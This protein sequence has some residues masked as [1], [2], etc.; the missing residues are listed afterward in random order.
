M[1]Y[2]VKTKTLISCSDTA[3]LI[4]AFVFAYGKSRFSHDVTQIE[5]VASRLKACSADQR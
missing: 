2:V 5:K 3:Q 4:C 1:I